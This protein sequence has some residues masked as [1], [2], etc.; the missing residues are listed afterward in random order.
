MPM[1]HLNMN[2]A[3]RRWP[4]GMTT[5]PSWADLYGAMFREW[6]G[7][8]VPFDDWL[9][10]RLRPLL[11][12]TAKLEV[13]DTDGQLIR[14]WGALRRYT[15]AY[16]IQISTTP[17]LVMGAKRHVMLLNGTVIREWPIDEYDGIF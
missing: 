16:C 10:E 6:H 15:V 5:F 3:F 4:L 14:S 12:A 2:E 11:E 13:F 17:G 8:S 9:F 1:N 7:S